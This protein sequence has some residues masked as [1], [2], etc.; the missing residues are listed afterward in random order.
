MSFE[1]NGFF[2][3]LLY[4]RWDVSKRIYFAEVRKLLNEKQRYRIEKI[5]NKLF[6]KPDINI[7]DIIEDIYSV[8]EVCAEAGAVWDYSNPD[9]NGNDNIPL[10]VVVVI[11]NLKLIC[12]LLDNG[13]DVNAMDNEGNHSLCYCKDSKTVNLLIER[14][15][16]RYSAKKCDVITIMKDRSDFLSQDMVDDVCNAVIEWD[17][18]LALGKV[19]P[20]DLPTLAE[21]KRGGRL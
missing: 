20:E 13:A 7:V 4:K 1:N 6:K 16:S 12:L 10:H 15:V 19:K 3:N 14:G 18:K 9:L 2:C 21:Q 8:F 11:G 5:F 17:K